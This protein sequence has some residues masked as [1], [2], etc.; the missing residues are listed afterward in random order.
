MHL[1]AESQYPAFFESLAGVLNGTP[2][3]H[4]FTLLGNLKTHLGNGGGTWREM[5]GRKCLP[6]LKE[7]SEYLL[8]SHEHVLHR[9]N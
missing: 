1:C 8:Q 5:T 2:N 3:G 9:R 7:Y 6:D 4:S